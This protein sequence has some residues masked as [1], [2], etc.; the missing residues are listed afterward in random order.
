VSADNA[1]PANTPPKTPPMGALW[2]RSMVALVFSVLEIELHWVQGKITIGI[3]CKDYFDITPYY[4]K[5][6]K[7]NYLDGILPLSDN[8]SVP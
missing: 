4:I 7:P 1:S 3:V 6:P 2:F 5:I 8:F